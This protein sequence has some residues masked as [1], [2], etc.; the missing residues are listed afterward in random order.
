MSSIW[1]CKNC[2][3][4]IRDHVPKH[5][6]HCGIE[7]TGDYAPSFDT[8]RTRG[9][10]ESA[11]CI[12]FFFYVGM[13]LLGGMLGLFT[14]INPVYTSLMLPIIVRVIWRSINKSNDNEPIFDKV[15]IIWIVIM[16]VLTIIFALF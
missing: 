5:C 13:F 12:S 4:E 14:R 9:S 8:M 10:E 11:T 3:K 2:G 15:F 7:L 6:P 1:R 16:I